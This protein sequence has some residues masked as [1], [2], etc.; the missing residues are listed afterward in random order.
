MNIKLKNEL[1]IYLFIPLLV[2]S[3]YQLYSFN[4]FANKVNEIRGGVITPTMEGIKTATDIRILSSKI[5]IYTDRVVILVPFGNT[6][7]LKNNID[8]IRELK[9]ER[10]EKIEE[11][12]NTSL[13][14]YPGYFGDNSSY[15]LLQDI[16]TKVKIADEINEGILKDVEKSPK[17]DETQARV[18]KIIREDLV[19]LHDEIL[20]KTSIFIDDGFNKTQSARKDV[21]RIEQNGIWKVYITSALMLVVLIF[22]Y[23]RLNKE[24]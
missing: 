21:S 18:S 11:L 13:S 10:L 12:K 20:N 15:S 1:I 5:S 23:I 2:I 7:E 3:V 4:S 19:P 22:C 16:E 14:L 17:N 8:A 9:P 6:D 24:K